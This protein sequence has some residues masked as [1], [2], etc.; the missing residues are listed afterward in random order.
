MAS[1]TQKITCTVRQARVNGDV[2]KRGETIELPTDEARALVGASGRFAPAD[3]EE[4]A[5]A[6]ERAA[7]EKEA[8]AKKA[9]SKTA[10]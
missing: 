10:S 8:P 6:E 1:K 4:A 7:S 2:I 3:S 9:A 5:K